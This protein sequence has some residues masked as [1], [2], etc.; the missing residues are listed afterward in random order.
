MKRDFERNLK[1]SDS[2]PSLCAKMNNDAIFAAART[3]KGKSGD[4]VKCIRSEYKDELEDSDQ[5]AV[6]GRT[7]ASVNDAQRARAFSQIGENTHGRCT[8]GANVGRNTNP[9][10]NSNPATTNTGSRNGLIQ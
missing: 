8:A 2:K 6:V 1:G 5:M 3:C 9:F 4:A 7:I 10:V